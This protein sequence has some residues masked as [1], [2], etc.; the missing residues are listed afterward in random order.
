MKYFNLLLP[1]MLLLSCKT[2]E[3]QVKNIKPVS[4]V[5]LENIEKLLSEG[6]YMK[7]AQ[8]ISYLRREEKGVEDEK[9]KELEN[10]MYAEI[11]AKFSDFI[12]KSDYEEALP[13]YLSLLNI[14]KNDL[15]SDWSIK[16][17]LFKTAE[18]FKSR[19]NRTIALYYYLK[20]LD[21]S[22]LSEEE[23]VEILDLASAIGNR[24]ALSIIADSMGKAGYPVEEEYKTQIKK[25]PSKPLMMNGTAIIWVDKGIKIE[26]GYGI[27]D[28]V[29]GSG[30]FVDEGGYMLT[31]HHVIESEV[32]PEYEGYSRLYIR[33]SKSVNEK[34]PAK[35]VGYDRIFDLALIKTSLTPDYVYYSAGN[36]EI[37]PG[38][39][40]LAIGAP[41][42]LE[43]TLTSGIVSNVSRRFIQMGDVM[44]IDAP[45]NP[46]NSGGPLLDEEDNLLGVVFAGLEMFEGLNFAIPY[47]W[48]NKVLPDLFKGGEVIHPWFG[49]ALNE[50]DKSLEVIYTVPGEP[51]RRA[52]I[53]AGDRI[54]ELNGREYTTIRDFQEAILH[55]KDES[56][57]KL[58]WTRDKETMQGII[59]LAKRPFSP[60][61]IALKKDSRN[62]LIL[63]IFG[64]EIKAVKNFLWET[65]YVVTRVIQGSIADNSNISEGDPLSIQR[66][67]VDIKKRIAVLQ[68]FVKKRKAGFFE[69]I[70]QLAA[71]LET[72]NFI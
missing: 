59:C 6:H 17:L 63:P 48:V 7:A 46:G 55:F 35:V 1:V 18:L 33:L 13:I 37:E 42:G 22:E 58:T 30:F 62:N 21:D 68:V 38:E 64:M 28:R 51:A 45:I 69:N 57:V 2:Y 27:P 11:V 47:N 8:D 61:E 60:L 56:L 54:K 52:G 25:K 4:E 43:N 70:I 66:W 44:Q 49:L 31:N 24:P 14:E 16:K 9:L 32:D 36:A 12:E 20:A 40:V 71:Y 41:L 53:Q 67:Y 19:E 72:D 5:Y 50:N 23:Y 34:I 26:Q 39:K 3:V 10:K 65:E 29:L 15:L